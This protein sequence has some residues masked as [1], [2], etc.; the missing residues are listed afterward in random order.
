MKIHFMIHQYVLFLTRLAAY[1]YAQIHD[2]CWPVFLSRMSKCLQNGQTLQDC[3]DITSRLFK[4]IAVRLFL[5]KK[6]GKIQDTIIGILRNTYEYVGVIEGMKNET[7][8]AALSKAF[9]KF[10][11]FQ[12]LK[13]FLLTVLRKVNPTGCQW[14]D[15]VIS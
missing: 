1:A 4:G 12:A 7:D 14:F 13:K 8:H 2:E 10:H 5:E 15:D 3:C 6:A 9:K 11:D